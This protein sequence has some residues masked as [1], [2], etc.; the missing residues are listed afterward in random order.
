MILAASGPTAANA[1]GLSLRNTLGIR[2]NMSATIPIP[3]HGVL[4]GSK[5]QSLSSVMLGI[6]KVPFGPRTACTA[7]INPS[8]PFSTDLS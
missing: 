5:A 6:T 8:G 4:L 2:Q 7:P 3:K 1:C